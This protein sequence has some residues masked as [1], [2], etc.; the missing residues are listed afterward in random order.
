MT[1]SLKALQALI[2]LA[3]HGSVR[4]AAESRGVTPAAISQ[5]IHL[6]SRQLDALLV[7]R[8]GP[9]LRLT[10]RALDYVAAI[11]PLLA[12]LEDETA[13]RFPVMPTRAVT[14]TADTLVAGLWLTPR[15]KRFRETNPQISVRLLATNRRLD[16]ELGEADLALRFDTD[17]L[18]NPEHA[19]LDR[20][21][22]VAVHSPKLTGNTSECPLIGYDF[23]P[24]LWQ[25]WYARNNW[26]GEPKRL[27]RH[28]VNDGYA[29]IDL[30]VAGEGMALTLAEASAA[31]EQSGRLVRAVSEATVE[32]GLVLVLP[33][34][35]PVRP[36]AEVLADYLTNRSE[37]SLKM[38]T[39][40]HRQ[41]KM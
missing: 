7:E 15:L 12:S 11:R 37:E 38:V 19:K 20:L 33:V 30:A 16:L 36:A 5:Q 39:R 26:R 34:K 21:T 25:D 29:A 32:I 6:L 2:A 35:R 18:S 41:Q 1:P 24:A 22:V 28:Q 3:D 4:A 23:A 9:L 8:N 40:A 14:I 27:L 13:S 31:H 17:T 10:P